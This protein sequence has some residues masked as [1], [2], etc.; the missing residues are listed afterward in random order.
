M[1]VD[2]A[3]PPLILLCDFTM[4]KS[5]RA[6]KLAWIFSFLSWGTASKIYL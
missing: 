4:A 5:S 3:S 2:T 1:G 6:A